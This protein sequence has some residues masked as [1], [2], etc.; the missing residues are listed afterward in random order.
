MIS[1]L[2]ILSEKQRDLAIFVCEIFSRTAI[3]IPG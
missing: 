2:Q 3:A 1:I